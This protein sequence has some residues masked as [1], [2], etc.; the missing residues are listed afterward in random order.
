MS[1]CGIDARLD[2]SSS[3]SNLDFLKKRR[4]VAIAVSLV[5]WMVV[6]EA[7]AAA[8]LRWL[9]HTAIALCFSNSVSTHS[10]VIIIALKISTESS[11]TDS[12]P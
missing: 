9:L 12:P 1:E 8:V 5:S 4:E 2:G 3:S 7:E 6:A 10:S 11:T